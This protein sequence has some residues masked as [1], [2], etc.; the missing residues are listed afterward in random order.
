MFAATRFLL[1]SIIL[2]RRS[3]FG[4]TAMMTL[5]GVEDR[6]GSAF[7]QSNSKKHKDLRTNF[8]RIKK[9]EEGNKTVVTV[10]RTLGPPIKRPSLV[11]HFVKHASEVNENF[12]CGLANVGARPHIVAPLHT[13]VTCNRCQ[14]IL[15]ERKQGNLVKSYVPL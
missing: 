1:W 14:R 6:Y 13:A 5:L 7:G 2:M 15:N 11:G 3:Y 12:L 9:D 4:P 10:K 8:T